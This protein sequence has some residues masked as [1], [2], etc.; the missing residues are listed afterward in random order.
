MKQFLLCLILLAVAGASYYGCAVDYDQ[1][2]VY[3]RCPATLEDRVVN[4]GV[5]YWFCPHCDKNHLTKATMTALNSKSHS[6]VIG[7]STVES[8]KGSEDGNERLAVE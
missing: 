2:L 3:V 6:E 4:E 8:G 7:S 1:P 5:V